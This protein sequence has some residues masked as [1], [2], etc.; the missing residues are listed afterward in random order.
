MADVTY[1]GR[2]RDLAASQRDAVL[3][4]VIAHREVLIV[5]TI[6]A[7]AAFL[8]FYELGAKALHHDES[9]HATYSWYL[10]DGR[11]YQH[12]PLMHGPF[13]FH[14]AAAMMFLFGDTDFSVRIIPAL[15]GTILVAM[16]LLLKKQIGMTAVIIA[17]VLLTISPSLL[18]FGR[19]LRE[20][21]YTTVWTFAMFICV[22]R[23]LD[24]G[25]DRFLYGL[26]AAMALAY[27]TKEVTF[28]TVAVL[29]LYLDL[30]LAFELGKRREG[31]QI[32]N[33]SVLIRS[34][35]YVPFAFVSAGL[36]PLLGKTP[37]GLEKMPRVGDLLVVVGT[38]AL[39]QFAAGIQVLVGDKGYDVDAE[40]TLRIGTVASLLVMSVYVG[41][42]WKPK[43]WLIAA[44]FFFVPFTLLFTT[45]F[46]NMDGFFSGIW[47]SLDY[48]LG[49][50]DV[51]RGNQPA[52]YY[53]LLTPLYEF[54]PLILAAAGAAWIVLRGDTSRRMLLAWVAGMFVGLSLA[55][56]KMPWLE[57]H[58]ALPLVVIA[59][60]SLARL[61]EALDLTASRWLTAIAAG[62][63]TIA[64]VLLMVDGDGALRILGFAGAA[65][66]GGWA[67][68]E[69]VRDRP[70]G[71]G[72]RI[73]AV[74]AS[75]ELR[76]TIA[77]LAV[78]AL[79]AVVLSLGPSGLD[80]WLGAW[81]LALVPVAILSHLFAAL[82]TGNKGF[83]RAFVVVVVAALMTLTARA[84]INV[85][86]NNPDTPVDMLVY[87][88]T[89]PDI[90]RLR[91]QIDDIAQRTGLGSNLPVVVDA[92]D[93]FTWPW[94][95]YLR[96]YNDVLYTSIGPDYKPKEG[97][98]LL[99]SRTNEAKIDASNYVE[100]P[101]KHRWWFCE[102]YRDPN[103]ECRVDGGLTFPQA[104]DIV[105]SPDKLRGLANFF[106]HRRPAE[107]RYLGSVDGVAF[108]PLQYGPGPEL[109]PREPTVL[110]DGRILLGAENASAGARTRGEFS[111]PGDVFV[112]KQGNVWVAD[113]LN[114]R[115]QKFDAKGAF[116]GSFGRA[117][118]AEGLF[119][120]PWSVAVD[121]QGF[122]YVAD[123]WNHRIQKF[124]ANFTFVASWGRPGGQNPGPLDLFGPRDIVIAADGTLWVTDTGNQRLLHFSNTGE[125]LGVYGA[126]GSAQG[127]FSE[128]VG[129][130][131]D[132]AGNLLVADTWNSRVQTLT[133]SATPVSSFPAP[134]ASRD[135]LAK[136]YLTVLTDGRIIAT[137]PESGL[138]VLYSPT[139]T[140]LGQWQPLVNSMPVGVAAMSDGG[141]AFTDIR[142]NEVQIVS[143]KLIPDLFK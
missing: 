95:W 90:P 94:A 141:F 32:S 97:A 50:H 38:L 58:L 1:N 13:Q 137:I 142:R 93:A 7:V 112:D 11:G 134:W 33:L 25:K 36:W 88:Q 74:F 107:S 104:N 54:L 120:E 79:G 87:T 41:L 4:W 138:L 31:E 136:P 57:T 130:T 125:S 43:V 96:D 27:A 111:Q 69:L 108:F 82:V 77:A 29:L 76:L 75:Q 9:L 117:G 3:E 37:F 106:L 15:F 129:L 71:I 51:R 12:N 40:D 2:G 8:H 21:I 109:S 143:A 133:A 118:T 119:N 61:I 24:E 35:A 42:L 139:G 124:D 65:A 52:Y 59:S 101:Y 62:A 44:A 10:Y 91:D 55:G 127:Q 105:T 46:F 73:A 100:V 48:W 47:G 56:E 123:T 26:A 64:A 85:S 102:S 60:I 128:P 121:D 115:I 140:R 22:W 70:V 80:P 131:R 84:A 122:I 135:V 63:G 39:P 53:A 132:T 72:S 99:V 16:P 68:A 98:V 34:L 92:T 78:A 66:L 49:Q 86:F 113:G 81:I 6:M 5:G 114:H 23:Y 17:M 83:G 116:L 45:F 89:S 67:L 20:D 103:A 30:A 18:Y 19:F 14:G 110:A 126:G 28:I